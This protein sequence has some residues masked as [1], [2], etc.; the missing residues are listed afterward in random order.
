MSP[1]RTPAVLPPTDEML[2]RPEWVILGVK[3]TGG[4]NVYAS[5]TLSRAEMEAVVRH[6][7]DPA[8]RFGPVCRREPVSIT[9][10]LTVTMATFVVVSGEDYP[11]ALRTL[12]DHWSPGADPIGEAYAI[13]ASM[14]TVELDPVV[15]AVIYCGATK[16]ECECFFPDGH[17]G[18]H[19]CDP[20]E[21]GGSWETHPD[22][23]V[24]LAW[25][26]GGRNAVG[27]PLPPLPYKEPA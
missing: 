14:P 15:D 27:V 21:C 19:V 9:Y 11:S 17:D 2:L 18:P 1:E 16:A 22:G 10:H 25:P 12:L 24:I 8:S 3:T 26:E 7:E 4:V 13:G 5:S 6:R 23:D 20:E